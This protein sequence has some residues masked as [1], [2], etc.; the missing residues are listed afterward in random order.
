MFS[1]L[2][3][4]IPWC[5]AACSYCS[6]YSK[7]LAAHDLQITVNLLKEEMRIQ[8]S[9]YQPTGPLASI[10]FGGG[11]PSLLPPEHVAD[12][13]HH[14]DTLFGLAP[15]AEITLEVNPG[16]VSRK[17]LQ[18][19][20]TAG[21][22]RLSLGLQCF[23]NQILA[24]LGR[25]HTTEEG[26][27]CF[28]EAR[29]VGFPSISIDLMAG[30]PYGSRDTWQATINTAR[31]L[32][33]DHI[34]LY[35]LTL[36]P[37]APLYQQAER[38]QLPLVDD[39]TVADMILDAADSWEQHDYHWYEIANFSRPGHQSQHNCGYWLRDGYLG[40]GPAAH[41]FLR[42]GYGH[43]FAAPASFETW[44]HGVLSGS[45]QQEEYTVLSREQAYSE[46]I[47]LGLRLAQG[48]DLA[49]FK[50]DWGDDIHERYHTELSRCQ[51]AGLLTSDGTT[52]RLT[53]QGRL[54]ANQ[55]LS[56]FIA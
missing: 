44:Q 3:I 4:H 9:R 50:R 14:A 41:S 48:L 10:Y 38:E 45:P 46:T 32:Q 47:F 49:K 1:R 31:M 39:D 40:L 8:A 33:P 52:I 27:A 19:F 30:L 20:R 17:S 36:S 7:P 53:A 6:F 43:R 21:V 13:V 42:S 24:L 23:D 56:L 55:V 28:Q 25:T 5:R 18:G 29:S 35:A 12:L 54:M 51:E 26:I 37:E 22:T 11:T 34:S 2:Y 15:E 16:T